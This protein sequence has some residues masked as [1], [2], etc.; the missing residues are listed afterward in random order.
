MAIGNLAQSDTIR[1]YIVFDKFLELQPA[2][3][4]GETHEKSEGVGK[5]GATVAHACDAA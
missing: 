3:I 4:Q 5:A 2:V 1:A